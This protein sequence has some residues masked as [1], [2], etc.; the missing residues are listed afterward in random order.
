[1][2]TATPSPSGRRDSLRRVLEPDPPCPRTCSA[3]SSCACWRCCTSSSCASCGRSGPRSAPCARQT[4]GTGGGGAGAPAAGVARAAGG[5]GGRTRRAAP[6][7]GDRAAEPQ[8]ATFELGP[9]VT[10]GPG[11]RLPHLAPR[12]HL[13]LPAPRPRL[14]AQRPGVRRRPRL[15]QR[16]LR[17]RPSRQRP[18]R[19]CTRATASR[20][21]PPSWRRVTRL[22]TELRWGAATDVGRVRPGNEDSVLAAAPSSPWPTAWAATPAA[23]WP[24]T[25]PSPRWSASGPQPHHRSLV[26]T[27][28]RRQRGHLR[29]RP[30]R[31]HPPRHGHHAHAVA[32][33]WAR[34]PGPP[35]RGERGRLPHLRGAGRR[36]QQITRD[37]TY[38]EDLVAAGEITADEARF[39]PQRHIVTRALG[40]RAAVA[41][42]RVGASRRSPATATSSAPT[43]SSTRSTTAR[44]PGPHGHPGPPDGGRRPRRAGQR[45]R[46]PGQ[47]HR[48][49]GRRTAP[50]DGQRGATD[51]VPAATQATPATEPL[52]G[53]L[54]HDLAH[55]FDADAD[56]PS[57][58]ATAGPTTAAPSA[59][60]RPPR[61]S[62]AW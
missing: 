44:S 42:R 16:H 29:P 14:R 20:S 35:G 12:R 55:G 46:R 27:C 40:H 58:G 11:R 23:R 60:R 10:V 49:R 9:E 22:M 50:A 33:P 39:H 24:A 59:P 54:P 41:G 7:G 6:P 5:A 25:S 34:R 26:P 45:G 52:G 61:P 51:V 8:G 47:H 37:H 38:V 36:A 53:W 3:S 62:D 30:R 28:A 2:R 15:H 56:P 43:A 18:D 57:A 21:A 32:L 1:M 17:E 13:R 31:A 4:E 48:H 19:A